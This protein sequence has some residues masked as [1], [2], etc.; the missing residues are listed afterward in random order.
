M[1]VRI[2][3]FALDLPQFEAFIDQSLADVLWFYA[4]QE[5]EFNRALEVCKQETDEIFWIYR[6]VPGQMQFIY[7]IPG[8]GPIQPPLTKEALYSDPFLTT[9]TIREYLKQRD[10]NLTML[11][12]LE[13]FAA[14]SSLPWITLLS[15]NYRRWWIGS[16]LYGAEQRLTSGDYERAVALFQKI[17]RGYN[18]DQPLPDRRYSIEDFQFP[19]LNN[20][21]G[22]EIGVWTSDEI[23]HALRLFEACEGLIFTGPP[24]SLWRDNTDW[25]TLVW[26]MINALRRMKTLSY[27]QPVMVSFIG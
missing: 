1:G 19:I 11:I 15:E 5:I 3:F 9:T 12:W 2:S 23:A 10:S 24:N 14:C 17:L 7:R 22:R 6:V 18:C 25:N 27:P 4:S 16:F 20:D 21:S 26:Q 13:C 8:P